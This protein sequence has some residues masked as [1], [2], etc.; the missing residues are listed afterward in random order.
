MFARNWYGRKRHDGGKDGNRGRRHVRASSGNHSGVMRL[1][2]GEAA[3]NFS[4]GRSGRPSYGRGNGSKS[5]GR[6]SH[7]SGGT[8]Q[9]LE[10]FG[11][12]CGMTHSSSARTVSLHTLLSCCVSRLVVVA[13]AA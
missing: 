7:G 12:A 11:C 6:R 13:F 1:G 2:G 5:G 8:R 3:G 10:S 9:W 4:H